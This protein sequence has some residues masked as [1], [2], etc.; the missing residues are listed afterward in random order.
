MLKA[1]Q[2]K[3]KEMPWNHKKV[4]RVMKQE[5]MLLTRP[6]H[7][8]KKAHDGKVETLFSNTRWCSDSFSIQCQ[9]GERVHVAFSLDTCDREAMRYI[10]STIGI[11]VPGVS[12]PNFL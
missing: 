4:Y 9:N 5:N 11:D 1:D 10:A 8:P 12:S 6:E 7:R 3:N 2:K